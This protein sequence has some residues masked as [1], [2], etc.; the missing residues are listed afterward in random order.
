MNKA[1]GVF[2]TEIWLSGEGGPSQSL[3]GTLPESLLGTEMSQNKKAG[4]V[5]SNNIRSRE[6]GRDLGRPGRLEK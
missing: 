2:R 4:A 3:P 6:S 1:A 5:T